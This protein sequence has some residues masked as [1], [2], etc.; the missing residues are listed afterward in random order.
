MTVQQYMP[1]LNGIYGT[2]RWLALTPPWGRSGALE[3]LS[4]CCR[5][6][7]RAAGIAAAGVRRRRALEGTVTDHTRKT[8]Y[9][10]VSEMPEAARHEE[11]I[12]DEQPPASATTHSVTIEAADGPVDA[13]Y[14]AEVPDPHVSTARFHLNKPINDGW[15][16]RCRCPAPRWADRARAT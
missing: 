10:G 12:R 11:A 8:D 5:S 9:P 2:G 4:H 15:S 6:P 1:F 3:L 14:V 13:S 7:S 16:W